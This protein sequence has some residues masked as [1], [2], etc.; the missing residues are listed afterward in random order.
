MLFCIT[1]QLSGYLR[2]F[3]NNIYFLLRIVDHIVKC[4]INTGVL[5]YTGQPVPSAYRTRSVPVRDMKFPF[6]IPAHYLL[7]GADR[8]KFFVAQCFFLYRFYADYCGAY[9]LGAARL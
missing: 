2:V 4:G 8:R 5:V 1:K 6:P 9:K 3:V 7:A